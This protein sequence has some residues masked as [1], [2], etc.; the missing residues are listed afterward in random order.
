MPKEVDLLVW[1]AML[2]GRY[3]INVIRTGPH[4]GELTIAEGAHVL[5]REP[6]DLS[7]D[8]LFGPDIADVVAWHEMTIR[9]VENLERP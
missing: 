7:F 5:H 3:T 4:R 8:A 1:T 6:V 2:D 9:F